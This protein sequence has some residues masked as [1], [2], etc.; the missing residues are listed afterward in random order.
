MAKRKET[1][2]TLLMALEVG[3]TWPMR[4]RGLKNNGANVQAIVQ[5]RG[6]TAEDFAGRTLQKWQQ[7]VDEAAPPF[8]FMLGTHPNPDERVFAAREKIARGVFDCEAPAG[9]SELILW[10]AGTHNG[11]EQGRLLAL[12]GTLIARRRGGARSVRVLFGDAGR[13]LFAVGRHR[14]RDAGFQEGC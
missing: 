2:G 4:M 7:L 3:A 8:R 10:S 6:E 12:A 5:D 14:G 11:E 1:G 9:P 13:P